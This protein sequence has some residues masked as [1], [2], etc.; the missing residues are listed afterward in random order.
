MVR[1]NLRCHKL[2]RNRGALLLAPA[3]GCL[4]PPKARL[5]RAGEEC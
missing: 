2:S 4:S 5:T 3:A 1:Y